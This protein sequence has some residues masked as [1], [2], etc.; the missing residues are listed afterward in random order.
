MFWY[1][2]TSIYSSRVRGKDVHGSKTLSMDLEITI[3]IIPK[4][5]CLPDA[6]HTNHS[7]RQDPPKNPL[8]T[9]LVVTTQWHKNN[10]ELIR[11]T[12]SDS[13]KGRQIVLLD[14]LGELLTEEKFSTNMNK[15]FECGKNRL[16]FVIGGSYGLPEELKSNYGSQMLSVS[17]ADVFSPDYTRI[18]LMEKIYRTSELR[19]KIPKER[20]R[21][22]YL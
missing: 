17:Y 9:D 6:P 8:I 21:S 13:A 10:D 20:L 22:K 7:E 18:L 4:K 11:G 19:N 16:T 14:P 15:W 3:R 5:Y 1:R 12:D 2:T